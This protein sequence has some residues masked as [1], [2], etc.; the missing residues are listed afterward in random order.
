MVGS[1]CDLP[2]VTC[3][4]D[5]TWDE[6]MSFRLQGMQYPVENTDP[7]QALAANN[8]QIKVGRCA[9]SAK[10]SWLLYIRLEKSED[11]STSA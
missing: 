10:T 9:I 11:V 7:V 5:Q 2:V 4:G 1:S 8:L 3:R 6:S